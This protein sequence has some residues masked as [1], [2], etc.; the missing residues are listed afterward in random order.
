M[1]GRSWL[2]TCATGL[3]LALVALPLT[4]QET[5]TL[6][7]LVRHAERADDGSDP[8]PELSE[9]GRA[10]A[11]CLAESLGDAGVDRIFSTTYIRT[12]R[13]ARPLAERLGLDI[14]PYDA[15]GL[16]DFAETLGAMGGTVLVVG[17][18]NTT[19]DL[20]RALGGDPVRPIE[21]DE[22]DRLYAVTVAG[23]AVTST[24]VRFC[25]AG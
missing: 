16:G 18:S 8:N 25:P 22:Y 4:A 13:T 14:E 19:P 17:H 1:I 6:V 24:L 23:D 5:P 21:H 12:R 2:T 9:T 11:E 10:R 15:R 20:V 7:L 3:T